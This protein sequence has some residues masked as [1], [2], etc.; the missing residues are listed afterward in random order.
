VVIVRFGFRYSDFEF[1]GRR[2]TYGASEKRPVHPAAARDDRAEPIG[3]RGL[4]DG[5]ADADQRGGRAGLDLPLRE[6]GRLEPAQRRGEEVVHAAPVA[7]G[8]EGLE[9]AG[10]GLREVDLAELPEA[11]GHVEEAHDRLGVAGEHEG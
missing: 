4:E 11:R 3:A 2:P 5:L 1:F 9:R 7:V 6:P 8:H 10:L